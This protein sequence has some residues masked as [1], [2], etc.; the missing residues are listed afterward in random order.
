MFPIVR[1]E[2]YNNQEYIVD[3]TQKN[4]HRH[5]H[6]NNEVYVSFSQPYHATWSLPTNVLATC[7]TQQFLTMHP[8]ISM[9]REWG[10]SYVIWTMNK[11]SLINVINDKIN[12]LCHIYHLANNYA[13]CSGTPYGKIEIDSVIK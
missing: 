11:Q 10:A 4:A 8:N 1:I 7:D 2:R 5:I 6:C 3:V 9:R 12:P 13:S